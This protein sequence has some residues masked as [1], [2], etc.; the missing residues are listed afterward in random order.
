MHPSGGIPY[1]RSYRLQKVVEQIAPELK[2]HILFLGH[3]HAAC[4]LPAYR[5]VESIMVGCFESQTPYL[6]EKALF[7]LIAG[8]IFEYQK[9]EDGLISS[10]LTWY[11]TYV[12]REN[13]FGYSKTWTVPRA[14]QSPNASM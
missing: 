14:I 13:D 6:R 8:A 2:P 7:P 12:P 10:N 1:A 11:P 9:D 4:W 5:N 3:L